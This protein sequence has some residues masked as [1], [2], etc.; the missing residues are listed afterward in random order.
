AWALA[1]GSDA[2]FGTGMLKF[3]LLMAVAIGA[4]IL[5]GRTAKWLAI[6]VAPLASGEE[7]GV[8]Y[9]RD[10][11]GTAERETMEIVALVLF[12][13]LLLG[14]GASWAPSWLGAVGAGLVVA[15]VV[16]DLMRWERASASANFV[17][18]QRGLTRKVHQIAMENIREVAVH[19]EEAR[20]FTLLHGVR[21]RI[22]R[23]HLKLHDK[24]FVS[25]PRTDSA[26]GLDDVETLANHVRAR[27]Q[28]LGERAGIERAARDSDMA[29][30]AATLA[31]SPEEREMRHEL[32]R[33]RR[34]TR[35][36]R[37]PGDERRRTPQH[38]PDPDS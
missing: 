21:N 31:L 34:K 32:K 28:L 19:E 4:H 5:L 16:L 23:V 15:A 18:F 12:A 1:A 37:A 10:V 22:C 35:A 26:R 13:G 30:L 27:L 25:L 2:S 33:L 9:Q 11:Y 7:E 14:L 36:E 8:R 3:A 24:H 29:P 38:E 20:G 17:W 6:A